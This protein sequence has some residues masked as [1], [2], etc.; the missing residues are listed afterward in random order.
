MTLH[1]YNNQVIL[2]NILQVDIILLYMQCLAITVMY[3]GYKV[4]QHMLPSRQNICSLNK[5]HSLLL[6]SV[7]V[8]CLQPAH[9]LN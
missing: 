8:T 5:N 7:V 6:T 3:I 4:N 9:K 1:N 2:V